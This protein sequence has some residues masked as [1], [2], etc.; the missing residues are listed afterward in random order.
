MHG[1]SMTQASRYAAG[2]PEDDYEESSSDAESSSDE[3]EWSDSD[4]DS[5]TDESEGN[6]WSILV[7]ESFDEHKEAMKERYR[8]LMEDM[9]KKAAYKQ[10]VKEFAS[11]M[12]D[13]FQQNYI[14]LLKRIRRLKRDPTYKK[15]DQTAKRM[16]L[17]DDMDK[18]EAEASAVYMRRVLLTR[19]LKQ[20]T[21]PLDDEDTDE[22]TEENEDSDE[23]TEENDE[24]MNEEGD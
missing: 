17:D 18:E 24:D 12:T 21:L 3:S 10:T 20:W 6:P 16:R 8:E 19:E 13:A 2:M 22:D 9:S 14:N 7:D 4:S 5:D 23:G 11:E 15:I 1:L